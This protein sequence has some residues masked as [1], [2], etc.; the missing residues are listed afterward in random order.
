MQSR[1]SYAS[2]NGHFVLCQCHCQP[3]QSRCGRMFVACLDG[4]VQEF[5]TQWTQAV[6][7]LRGQPRLLLAR[8]WPT[9]LSSH[10]Q[11]WLQLRRHPCRPLRAVPLPPTIHPLL[12]PPIPPPIPPPMPP[13]IPPPI[14]PLIPPPIPPPTRPPPRRWLAPHARA[15][16]P[17]PSPR[18]GQRHHRQGAHAMLAALAPLWPLA[19]RAMGLRTRASR[20]ASAPLACRS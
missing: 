14:P 5:Y 11:A 20:Q 15:R 19:Q 2:Y 9:A 4:C 10:R 16:R 6:P 8:P 18:S 7:T 13:P 1:P 12:A 17:L 3:T